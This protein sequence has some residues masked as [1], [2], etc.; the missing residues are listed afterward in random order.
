MLFILS[1][2]KTSE[3]NI[4]VPKVQNEN[5]QPQQEPKYPAQY[6]SFLKTLK[7]N[8]NG[9]SKEKRFFHFINKD[10]PHYWIGT[11]W[12]FNGTTRT[13]Q[14]GEIACGYFVTNVLSDFGL[15][16][17]RTYLAQQ[18]SSKMIKEICDKK[19]IQRFSDFQKLLSYLSRAKE[20]EIFIIGL[21]YHTGFIIKNGEDFYF[22]HSNFVHRKGV[23]KEK[24][25]KSATLRSS[26]SFMIGS[27][28]QN[29]TLFQ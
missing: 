9:T 3:S 16:I 4:A 24:I 25:Q 11:K 28:T 29:T 10:V 18:P 12:D 27:L 17:R 5:I 15:K 6:S 13:P 20:Q 26:K 21:D 14:K 1:C 8:L 7:Q 19:S 2:Q 22:L 23:V